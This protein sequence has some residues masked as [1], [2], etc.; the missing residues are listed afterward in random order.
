VLAEAKPIEQPIEATSTPAEVPPAVETPA[1]SAP[2]P[3]PEPENEATLALRRQI[4]GL[5]QSAQLQHR[6]SAQAAMPQ[7]PMTREQRL[8]AWHQQGGLSSEETA[9]FQ[10]HGELLDFPE[11]TAHAVQLAR[12]AGHERGTEAHLAAV[13]AAFDA[14]MNQLQAQAEPMPTQSFDPPS[15]PARPA[16][17]SAML[18]APVSRTIPSGPGARPRGKVVLSP[19]EVEVARN[20]GISVEEYARQKLIYEGMRERGEYRDNRER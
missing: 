16:T 4:E 7:Q 11:V 9:F 8:A 3:Q 5:K 2:P 12:R 17:P 1:P 20:S 18:S 6:Q 15:P 13:K 19:A 10:K 14:T